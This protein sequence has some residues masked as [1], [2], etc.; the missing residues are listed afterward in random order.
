MARGSP[1]A[2]PPSSAAL[3]LAAALAEDERQAIGRL[4]YVDDSLPGWRRVRRGRGVAY[5]DEQGRAI[6]DERHLRRIRHLAIPPAY[7]DVWICPLEDGHI[8]ATG[9]DARGRKQYRYHEL[10]QALRDATKFERMRDFGL[11]LPRIRLVVQRDL[12]RAGLPREKVLAT[13]VRLLDTTYLRVGNDEYARSN[14]SFGLTTLRNRHAEIRGGTLRLSFRGKSGVH[15]RVQLDDPEV[16]RICRKLQELPGQELFQ[17]VDD[18][19]QPQSIGSADVNDYIAEAAAPPRRRAATGSGGMA[20]PG[21]QRFTAK[22]FRTWHASAMALERLHPCD[23][24]SAA[25]AKQRIKAVIADVAKQ[26]GHTLTVC[27]KSYVHPEVLARFTDG[28]LRAACEGAA[29]LPATQARGLG[30]AERQLLG[31]LSA[32]NRPPRS[33]GRRPA[34]PTRPRRDRSPSTGRPMSA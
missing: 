23:A 28:R 11:A 2:A 7:T 20:E 21:G 15:Q 3:A 18:N 27:R 1:A 25:E 12:G 22:D 19:G 9:R 26:L 4:I 14:G 6:T 33:A 34:P 10:W 30:E 8:Q 17:C 31:L 5:L 24:G 32:A 13:L 29:R 16:A